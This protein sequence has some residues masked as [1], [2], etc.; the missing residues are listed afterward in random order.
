MREPIALPTDDAT[1]AAEGHFGPHGRILPAR[2][3]PPEPRDES[4]GEK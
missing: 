3:E 1:P 4:E 2:P